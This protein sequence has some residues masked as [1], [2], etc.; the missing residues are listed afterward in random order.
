MRL[1]AGAL[2]F[3]TGAMAFAVTPPAG[4]LRTT[5]AGAESF[6]PPDLG[7]AEV[8]EVTAYAPQ[9]R[10]GK[11]LNTWLDGFVADNV[12]GTTR[13]T[14]PAT[15]ENAGQSS[16]VQIAFTNASGQS[17][18][19][20]FVATSFDA[21][22]V[23]V[24]RIVA[25]PSDA[26]MR[27]YRPG[28]RELIDQLASEEASALK[29]GKRPVLATPTQ[30]PRA[31]IA[32]AGATDAR[33]FR[34]ITLPGKGVPAANIEAT[35]HSTR[36]AYTAAGYT[37][38]ET[39]YLFLRDGTAYKDLRCPPDQLDVEASR[40]QEPRHWGRW[41]K[42]GS[43][44]EVQFPRADGTLNDWVAPT[45]AT[46]GIPGREGERLAG[47]FATA[48]AYDIPGGA[49]RVSFQGI[50][51]TR[52]G[53]FE[54]DFMNVASASSGSGSDRV[55]TGAV[56]TDERS[57]VSVSGP[58]LGGGSTTRANSAKADRAGRYEIN[59][60]TLILRY[61]N[62]SVERLPFY[63]V[64]DNKRGIFFRGAVYMLPKPK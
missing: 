49:G 17:V 58:S 62:G 39:N 2:L 38:I 43:K 52:D 34:W 30:E 55:V 37:L 21:E 1:L 24:L 4:W 36:Q 15:L 40:K 28:T 25:T 47:R 9:T 51:F 33:R 18:V 50:T 56:A 54:S 20:I 16:Q 26:V 63:Y 5:G 46:V 3:L 7:A 61:D 35:L 14:V 29:A 44:Y 6:A 59:G 48:S 22:R 32:T 12:P 53:R 11:A 27:R 31:S 13:A 41:R 8:Y 42:R 23:R 19:A 64:F 57:S 60:Y 10:A 45:M